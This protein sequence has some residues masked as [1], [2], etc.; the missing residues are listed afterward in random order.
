MPTAVADT[1]DVPPAGHSSGYALH[2]M[3]WPEAGVALGHAKLAIIPVGSTE[4][5][6]PHLRLS[7]DTVIAEQ[8]ALRLAAA[9]APRAIVVPALPF[10]VSYHH[11]AFPG[12]LTLSPDTLQL[13]LTELVESL[14]RH[15][16]EAFFFLTGHGGN[17]ATLQ[18]L[19]TKLRFQRGVRVASLFYFTL[20]RD[21]MAAGVTSER[22]GHACEVETSL[23]LFLQPELVAADRLAAGA[24]HPYP[25][26]YSDHDAALSVAVPFSFAELT[27]NG[28]FGD[29]RRTDV[30]FGRAIAEAVIERAAAFLR[31]FIAGSTDEPA[32]ASTRAEEQSRAHSP[33]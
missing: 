10:G 32:I 6:G 3:T 30:A 33:G 19:A 4:Q 9:L 29:A 13:V 18:V 1:V 24:V 28:A 27:A 23:A 25:Y 11:M 17:E 16:V 12:T 31:G 7:T 8:F 22:W 26:P 21:V 5:H 20:V 15:G 14:Q 2:E